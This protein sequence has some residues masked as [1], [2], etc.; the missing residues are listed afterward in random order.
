MRKIRYNSVSFGE[1]FKYRGKTFIKVFEPYG[2]NV[3]DGSYDWFGS[4]QR[5]RKISKK[6]NH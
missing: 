5:V 4:D 6:R 1:W 2:K 3:K